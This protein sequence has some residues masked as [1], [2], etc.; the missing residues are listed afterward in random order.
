MVAR[1]RLSL[2]CRF[3][4]NRAATQQAQGFDRSRTFEAR[5]TTGLSGPGERRCGPVRWPRMIVEIHALHLACKRAYS[6][7]EAKTVCTRNLHGRELIKYAKGSLSTAERDG[8]Q[9]D[10]ELR[11]V[12][13]TSRSAIRDVRCTSRSGI[14]DAGWSVKSGICDARWTARS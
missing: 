11:D 13:C 5:R 1:P 12:G 4:A 9:L 10:R 14:R 2:T 3:R 6:G 8:P 7:R